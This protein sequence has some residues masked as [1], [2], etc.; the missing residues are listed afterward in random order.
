MANNVRFS[1]YADRMSETETE[2]EMFDL[3]C[4]DCTAN[5]RSRVIPRDGLCSNM[6][7]EIRVECIK[8][9]ADEFEEGLA[10]EENAASLKM[11]LVTDPHVSIPITMSFRVE[12][13]AGVAVWARR[14]LSLGCIVRYD[15]SK[16]D[17]DK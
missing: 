9:Q 11:F 17:E 14:L 8:Q 7:R 1:Q 6:C 4:H 13:V 2:I 5:F 15:L 12:D 10:E 16:P 3:V